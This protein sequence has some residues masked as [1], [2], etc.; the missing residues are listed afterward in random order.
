FSY[1]AKNFQLASFRDLQRTGQ[2]ISKKING[3]EFKINL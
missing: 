1:P 2:R 3:G